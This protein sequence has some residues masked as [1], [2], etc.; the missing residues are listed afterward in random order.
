M[1][2]SLTYSIAALTALVTF[3]CS[4]PASEKTTAA[5]S[6]TKSTEAAIP[7]GTD[8]ASAAAGTAPAADGDAY[9]PLSPTP[10][11][12]KAIADAKASGDKK[13]LAA[14][15]S[16]RG[17]YRTNEDATAGQR[18][19]YRAALSDYRNAIKADKTNEQ[20]IAGKSQIEQIYTMMGRPIPSAEECDKVSET[21][22]YKP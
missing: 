15:F 16:A 6:E 9:A 12:D 20:A 21:G 7:V 8:A 22:T 18:V 3:G 10:D 11:L 19:K 14:A 2:K 1:T 4:Q 13:K 17:D 5:T